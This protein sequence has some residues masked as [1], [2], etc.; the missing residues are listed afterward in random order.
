MLVPN[1]KGKLFDQIREV[2]RFHHYSLRTE[3][4]YCQWTRRYLAFHRGK[5]RSG[6]SKG[7]RHPRELGAT[8]VAGFLSHLAV[9]GNVSASTQNQA[10]NALVFLYE[11]VLQISLGDIGEYARVK[12]P[13]RLPEVLTQEETRTLLAALKPGTTRLILR[14]LYGTGMRLMECLRL[15]I[16]DL[17]FGRGR[18][19]VRQGKGDKDR[20]TMLPDKLTGELQEH[21]ERVKLLHERDLSEGFG[22]VFLPYALARKYPKADR[23]WVW[24]YVFPARGRSKDPRSAAVRRHH[25]GEMA[26][27][28]AMKE[29]VRLAKLPRRASCHTLRHCFATHLLEAGYDL[30]TVQELLGHENVATTQIYTHVMQKP[31]IGTRSPLDNL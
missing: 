25:C 27:Q 4:T 14:L 28:R 30:R 1:P 19:I 7:W 8:E 12:R 22:S 24:Q 29:A 2:M 11:Q 20:V 26:V 5:D 6:P 15:R 13:A 23:E 18:I 17:D 3:R 31:G 9:T 21:L 10:L 16:K